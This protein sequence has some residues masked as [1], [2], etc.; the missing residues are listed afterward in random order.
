[1]NDHKVSR[2]EIETMYVC[3]AVDAL[4]PPCTQAVR[5]THPSP[6]FPAARFSTC[7]QQVSRQ[8]RCHAAHNTYDLVLAIT[9][10]QAARHV[11]RAVR[12]ITSTTMISHV[13]SLR[14]PSTVRLSAVLQRAS[15]SRHT[16]SWNTRSEKPDDNRRFLRSLYVGE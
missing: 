4:A 9:P 13:S 14:T 16:F 12:T 10:A 11:L 7:G 1:M 2:A 8:C 3:R 5:G 6:S 15:K